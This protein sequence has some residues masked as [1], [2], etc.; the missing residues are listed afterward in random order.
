MLVPIKC[1]LLKWDSKIGKSRPKWL[2]PILAA[3]HSEFLGLMS[4]EIGGIKQLDV[5]WIHIFMINVLLGLGLFFLAGLGQLG[6]PW[7]WR[8]PVMIFSAEER[9][10]SLA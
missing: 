2:L 7:T 5:A 9:E 3:T 6:C 1:I 4:G 10:T 8:R